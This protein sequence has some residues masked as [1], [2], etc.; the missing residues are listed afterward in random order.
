M[1]ATAL[2][3]ALVASSAAADFEFDYVE[4]AA[5]HDS[6]G[7]RSVVNTGIDRACLGARMPVLGGFNLSA[8]IDL[9][10]GFERAAG[11]V[12]QAFDLCFR[13][14][15]VR[16]ERFGGDAETTMMYSAFWTYT[17][18]WRPMGLQ[19]VA[20]VGYS[21]AEDTISAESAHC[22]PG[23]IVG[24]LGNGKLDCDRALVS[25]RQAFQLALGFRF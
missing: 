23:T 25:E 4:I 14:L 1:K 19:P 16:S 8:Q 13:A 10:H 17:P 22:V 18:G 6:T 3:L 11:L 12:T 24:E 21:W 2:I 20:K 9:C 5:K 7:G 15:C